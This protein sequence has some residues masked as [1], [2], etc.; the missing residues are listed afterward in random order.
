MALGVGSRNEV[1][2]SEAGS[3]RRIAFAAR[4]LRVSYGE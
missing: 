2:R 3:N 1:N 4:S